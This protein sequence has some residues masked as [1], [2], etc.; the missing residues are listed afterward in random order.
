[1]FRSE[2]WA[3]RLGF[4]SEWQLTTIP[5]HASGT[6]QKFFPHP[7]RFVDHKEQAH[8]RKQAASSSSESAPFPGQRFYLDFGFM[9][10][11]NSDYSQPNIELD[12]VVES[13]DG[14]CAYLL[15][16]DDAFWV[17]LRKSTAHHKMVALRNGMT[18]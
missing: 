11:S 4:C 5:R 16:V 15:I 12:R 9:R 10:A 17:F 2:L 7:L 1:V 3:A 6:P 14:F 8:I 13:F 18:L